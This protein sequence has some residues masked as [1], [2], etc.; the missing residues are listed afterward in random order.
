MLLVTPKRKTMKPENTL[1]RFFGLQRFRK[2]IETMNSQLESMGVQ[3]LRAR[4]NEG[5]FIKVKSSLFT[6]TYMS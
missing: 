1:S 5:F 3:R 4:T 2:R 6:T